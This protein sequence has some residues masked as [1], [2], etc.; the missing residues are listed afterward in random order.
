MIIARIVYDLMDERCQGGGC[1]NLHD[2]LGA[3]DAVPDAYSVEQVGVDEVPTCRVDGTKVEEVRS[4]GDIVHDFLNE[5][6][7]KVM[8][9]WKGGTTRYG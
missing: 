8:H 9:G 5:L 2:V 6:K 3:L 7:R 1:K 4:I